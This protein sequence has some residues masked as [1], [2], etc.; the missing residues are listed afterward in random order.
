[1]LQQDQTILVA[2]L[3]GVVAGAA[4]TAIFAKYTHQSMMKYY[5]G[6]G[7]LLGAFLSSPAWAPALGTDAVTVLGIIG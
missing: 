3:A 2:N 6:S 1:M 5:A 7:A 4:Y